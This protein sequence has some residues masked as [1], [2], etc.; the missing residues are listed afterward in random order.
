MTREEL[1]I[2]LLPEVRQAIDANID[3]DPLQI[4]LDRRITHAREVASQVKY[5]QRARTKLPRLYEARAIIPGRAFEQ[6]S[7]E[8]CA[9]AKPLRGGRLLDLTCGLG[10]DSSAM[11]AHF[12][13]VVALERDEM[14]ADVVRENNQTYRLGWT[15]QCKDGTKMGVGMPEYLLLFR[16]PATDRTNAYA[17]EPVVKQKKDFNSDTQEWQNPNGYSRARWQM[18]AHGY[19][20]SSGNRGVTPEEMAQLSHKGSLHPQECRHWCGPS[21]CGTCQP[22]P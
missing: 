7:S 16:K 2:L 4:A 18:D 1:D 13:R 3:R 5:L 11:A 9:V 17:D 6:S 15:E 21:G 8:D 14:L 22:S 12:E 19:T 10:I 20:R